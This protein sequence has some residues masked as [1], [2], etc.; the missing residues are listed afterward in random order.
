MNRVPYLSAQYSVSLAHSM[1]HLI[2]TL[3]ILSQLNVCPHSYRSIMMFSLIHTVISTVVGKILFISILCLKQTYIQEKPLR[4]KLNSKRMLWD[5]VASH[6][7]CLFDTF[8]PSVLTCL[9]SIIVVYFFFLFHF[10]FLFPSLKWLLFFTLQ[11]FLSSKQSSKSFNSCAILHK[12]S[13][14]CV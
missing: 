1:F 8:I 11:R 2:R 4:R 5:D 6:R 7:L 9:Q 13:C 14:I 12:A 3:F 10:L